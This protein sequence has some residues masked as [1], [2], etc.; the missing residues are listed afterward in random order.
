MALGSRWGLRIV[1]SLGLG[2]G[3]LLL[4][5]EELYSQKVRGQQAGWFAFNMPWNDSSPSFIG[6]G[7]SGPITQ[8]IR[9][10]ST[11]GTLRLGSPSGPRIRLFGVTMSGTLAYPTQARAEQTAARLAKLGFNLVRLFP[12][13]GIYSSLSP[14]TFNETNLDLM[15]YFIKQLKDRGIYVSIS[16]VGVGFSWDRPSGIFMPG[17]IETQKNAARDLLNRVN[18]YTGLALKDDPVLAHVHFNNE[19]PLWLAFQNPC[20]FLH[21]P[22]GS[23]CTGGL[24][25]EEAAKLDEIWNQKLLAHY[26]N[27]TNLQTAWQCSGKIGLQST[28]DPTNGTVKRIKFSDWANY[29]LKRLLDEVTLYF[30]I[31]K[32]FVENFYNFLT[33]ELGLQVPITVMNNFYG[34]PNKMAQARTNAMGQNVQWAHPWPFSGGFMDPPF[35]FLN[36]PMTKGPASGTPPQPWIEWKNT[37]WKGMVTNAVLGKP[38]IMTEYNHA[39]PNEFQAEMPLIISA[40]AAFQGWDVII[41]HEYANI[42]SVQAQAAGQV[43]SGVIE[44]GF[45]IADNPAV[46]AQIPIAARLFR[47]GWVSEGS[48]TVLVPF[49]EDGQFNGQDGSLDD[50]WNCLTLTYY[51]YWDKQKPDGGSFTA[52]GT[53]T[54]SINPAIALTRKVRMEL[55]TNKPATLPTIPSASHPYVSSTGELRW[56][57][58]TGN[59]GLVT[60]NSSWVNAAIGSLNANPQLDRL[61]VNATSNFGAI[62]LAPLDSQPLASSQK[63]L[64]TAVGRIQNTSMNPASPRSLG[65]HTLNSWGEAPVTMEPVNAQITLNLPQA[66]GKVVR[67][68][69]LDERGDLSSEIPVTKSGNDYTFSIGNHNTLWYGITIGA[70][71]L[72]FRVE[73]QTGNVYAGQYFCGLPSNCYMTGSADVAERIEVSE[74]VEPGDVVEVDPQNPRQYRKAKEPYSPRAAGV[75]SARPGFTLAN[76]PEESRAEMYPLGLLSVRLRLG[77]FSSLSHVRGRAYLSALMDGRQMGRSGARGLA[78]LAERLEQLRGRPLLALMGRV[79]VKATVENGPIQVGDLLVSS[80]KPGYAMRCSEPSLCVIGVIGK[81]LEPLREGEGLIEVLVMS[82]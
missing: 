10:N 32:E 47:N 55:L 20:N 12:I 45:E 58:Q 36:W 43:G 50:W 74:P 44:Q 79:K 1:L 30:Q 62:A 5:S 35:T 2:L 49:W 38:Y 14:V 19:S 77:A 63:M 11:D 64:L 51:C 69:R 7:T 52:K 72:T 3:L 16:L 18:P 60:V 56:N 27:R 4:G 25:Q 24:S 59:Y 15:F 57:M 46:L 80:S 78:A 39:L 31:E 81:A 37:I 8:P 66:Q 61:K 48:D 82:R 76:Q 40:Y 73:R 42:Y 68:F 33:L 13:D 6:V 41:L 65:Q 26:T 75:I 9:V 67:V 21:Y 22:P 70:D 23:G 34:I 28:E 17:L 53:V 71:G 29:C 54:Q